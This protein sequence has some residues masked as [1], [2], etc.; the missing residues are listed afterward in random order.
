MLFLSRSRSLEPICGDWPGK[1]IYQHF[2]DVLI[3]R[4]LQYVI[5]RP[6]GQI[7]PSHLLSFRPYGKKFGLPVFL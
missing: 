3:E 5:I 4:E 1:S 7:W 6:N 2:Y